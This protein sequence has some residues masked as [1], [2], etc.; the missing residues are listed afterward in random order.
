MADTIGSKKLYD[1]DGI[2]FYPESK[3]EYIVS[4]A[5]GTL[6]TVSADLAYINNRITNALKDL[7]GG[8]QIEGDLGLTVKYC[9][10]AS[11]TQSDMIRE[12][13]AAPGGTWSNSF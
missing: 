1:K 9:I 5:L 4:N 6:S 2:Q 8:S 10:S 7:T 13:G 12:I 11:S 3:A